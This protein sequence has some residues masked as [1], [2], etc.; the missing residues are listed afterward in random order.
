VGTSDSALEQA[1][2]AEMKETPT[3]TRMVVVVCDP[4]FGGKVSK[5]P[6]VLVLFG[7]RPDSVGESKS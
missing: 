2:S 1:C 7:T 4:E 6:N 3:R 5:A